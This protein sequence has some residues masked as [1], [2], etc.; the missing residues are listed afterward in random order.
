MAANTTGGAT[1]KSG[2]VIGD[3]GTTS[4]AVR[5]IFKLCMSAALQENRT[6]YNTKFAK[7]TKSEGWRK[8]ARCGRSGE[9]GA[10]E[11]EKVSGRWRK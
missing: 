3:D 11:M 10:R 5:T 6:S 8:G 7:T 4:H 9:R 2:M 1:V